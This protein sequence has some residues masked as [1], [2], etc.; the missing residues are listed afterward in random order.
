ME[1]WSKPVQVA[2]VQTLRRRG[3]PAA[4]LVIIDEAHCQYKWL[5]QQM[6]RP[7]WKDVPLIGLSA[8][9]W[10]KGLGRIFD[11]LVVPVT[12]SELIELQLLSSF[13]VYA[14]GHPQLQ[15]VKTVRGDYHEQQ[16][17]KVMSESGLVADIVETWLKL[18]ENRPT[19]VF[20]VDRAHAR[21]IRDR[22]EAAGVGCGYID[23]DTPREERLETRKSL[24]AAA[25]KVVANL[26]CLTKGVDGA[27]GCIILA[28]PTKSETLFV[29]DGR[30]RSS[31]EPR[32]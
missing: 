23:C 15:D 18:A 11:D 19:V 16:L 6:A 26:G 27:L 1:N 9:P 29:A 20:C 8:T 22:F 2:S 14:S 4:D 28:R 10:S 13:R 30:S 21:K 31:C 24:E 12:I 7:E 3:M 32:H 17:S 5:H 25:I